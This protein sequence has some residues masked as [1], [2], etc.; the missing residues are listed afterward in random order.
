MRDRGQFCNLSI[1]NPDTMRKPWCRN[2]VESVPWTP[3]GVEMWKRHGYFQG[4]P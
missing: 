2:C 1:A 4:D 3:E